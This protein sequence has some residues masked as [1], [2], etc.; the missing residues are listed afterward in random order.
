MIN[1]DLKD[2]NFSTTVKQHSFDLNLYFASFIFRH[3]GSLNKQGNGYDMEE[4]VDK[5]WDQAE[6][7]DND[8]EDLDNSSARLFERSRIKA[9][10]G[11]L[12]FELILHNYAEM[13]RSRNHIFE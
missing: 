10:A 6:Y 1:F 3:P 5:R 11:N 9:L 12:Y 2:L 4:Y 8:G 7:D 13:L